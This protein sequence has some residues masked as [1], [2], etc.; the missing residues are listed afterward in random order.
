MFRYLPNPSRSI[1]VHSFSSMP[2]HLFLFVPLR[3]N[4]RIG[5]VRHLSLFQ[6]LWL[7]SWALIVFSFSTDLFGVIISAVLYGIGLVPRNLHFKRQCS[8]LFVPERTG[9]ANASFST[10]TDLGIGLGA[11]ML[12]WVSQ[13]HK[14]PGVIY[15]Q[16]CVGRAFSVSVHFLCD[17][18]VEEQRGSP[19]D[20]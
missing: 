15:C 7:Q 12:G 9:V 17:T 4:F 20:N 13:I 18:F 2:R 6:P 5:T 16:R 19:Y 10:A 11:I 14:L 1:Q 3:E 8:V